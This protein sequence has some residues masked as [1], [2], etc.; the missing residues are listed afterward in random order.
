LPVTAAALSSGSWSWH[1]GNNLSG[2]P[3]M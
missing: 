3:F 1:S 2:A